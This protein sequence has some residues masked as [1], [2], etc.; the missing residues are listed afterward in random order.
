MHFSTFCRN[1]SSIINLISST[2][3]EIDDSL[4]LTLAPTTSNISPPT[5][6]RNA[7]IVRSA[8]GEPGIV[9][10]EII[11][12]EKEVLDRIDERDDHETIATDQT[13]KNNRNKLGAT[14]LHLNANDH[15][16]Q[17]GHTSANELSQSS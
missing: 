7:Q 8:E 16:T 14:G 11:I 12:H 13:Q 2:N 17:N 10:L 5:S 15:N 1:I 9:D 4:P 3:N 6:N